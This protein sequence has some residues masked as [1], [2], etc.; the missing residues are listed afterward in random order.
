MIWQS[1]SWIAEVA[2][3]PQGCLMRISLLWGGVLGLVEVYLGFYFFDVLLVFL[4]VFFTG[5]LICFSFI[6]ACAAA[7]RAMGIR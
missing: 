6:A 3:V 2:G 1:R 4:D 7:R 5:A